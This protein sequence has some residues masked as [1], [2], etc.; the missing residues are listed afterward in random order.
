M[1]EWPVLLLAVASDGRFDD[2]VRRAN[3]RGQLGA[4]VDV[5]F[6]VNVH[7]MGGYR[8][9]AD[10]EPV[11]DLTV[12]KAV[13]DVTDDLALA[14]TQFFI[15]DRF[16]LSVRNEVGNPGPIRVILAP[17]QCPELIR[18]ILLDEIYVVKL[19]RMLDGHRHERVFVLGGEDF[20]TRRTGK[21]QGVSLKLLRHAGTIW[22]AFLVVTIHANFSDARNAPAGDGVN[23]HHGSTNYFW[24][25][26]PAQP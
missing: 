19:P 8:P 22:P 14:M 6:F 11:C 20:A 25:K 23:V 1:H 5:Q 15:E 2:A 21:S 10:A 12:R 26:P 4:G 18:L 16:H 7:E 3:D 13:V 24:P 9:F 17:N